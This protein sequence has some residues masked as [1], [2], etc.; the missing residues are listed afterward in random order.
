MRGDVVCLS[1]RRWGARFD[2]THQ[3]MARLA[4]R[5]RV[6]VIEE[7]AIDAPRATPWMERIACADGLVVCVPHLPAALGD[8]RA[9]RAQ[10]ALLDVLLSQRAVEPALVWVAG[11]ADAEARVA[12]KLACG[13]ALIV[14]DVGAAADD[15]PELAG[16]AEQLRDP[17][18]EADVVLA[19]TATQLEHWR[20]RH[21]SAHLVP[22]GLDRAPIALARAAEHG[23]PSDQAH[24]HGP[25]I[26][27]PLAL[28]ERV[29]AGALARLA[30]ERAELTFVSIGDATDRAAA[31]P[32][33]PNL[34]FLGARRWEE[35]PRYYAGWDVALLPLAPVADFAER[36]RVARGLDP[37]VALDLVAAGVPVVATP[38]PDLAPLASVVERAGAP[39]LLRI[40]P[41]DRLAEAVDAALRQSACASTAGVPASGHARQDVLEACSWDASFARLEALL[42]EAI[43]RREDPRAARLRSSA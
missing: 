37:R 2:R 11:G 28:D 10:A 29:D 36:G 35:L 41:A 24:L 30:G 26:G 38:H 12:R 21:R 4:R 33:R 25:R 8:V 39:D 7:P 40:V 5:G 22:D 6:L 19:A 34:Y 27:I 42:G 43:A 15:A 23:E 3:W 17:R 9:H 18:R 13:R 32:V 16:P 20:R 14:H 31:L 1:A